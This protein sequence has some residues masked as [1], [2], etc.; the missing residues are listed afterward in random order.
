VSLF[1]WP[2]F[3][4]YLSSNTIRSRAVFAE[5]PVEKARIATRFAQLAGQ[6]LLNTRSAESRHHEEATKGVRPSSRGC[7]LWARCLIGRSRTRH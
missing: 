6:R 5:L 2:L 1:L 3:C 7:R 4:L